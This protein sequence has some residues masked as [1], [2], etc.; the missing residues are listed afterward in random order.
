MSEN[1]LYFSKESDPLEYPDDMI[2]EFRNG[3]FVKLPKYKGYYSINNNLRISFEKKPN[4][5]HRIMTR[6]L[7]GWRWKNDD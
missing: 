5:F 1:R 3:I 4:W 7:L 6:L 2:I